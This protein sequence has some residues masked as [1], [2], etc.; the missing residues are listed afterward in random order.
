VFMRSETVLQSSTCQRTPHE[1]WSIERD[2]KSTHWYEASTVFA[3]KVLGDGAGRSCLVVGSP[4]FEAFAL[5]DRGWKVTYLDIRKPPVKFERFVQCDAC[6]MPFDDA[7]FDAVSSACVLTHVGLG[8]YGD[9]I[10]ENGDEKALAEMVRVMKPGAKAAITFGAV[11]DA[12]RMVRDGTAHRI[13]TVAEA[14]RMIQSAGLIL[15]EFAIWEAARKRWRN[16]GERPS[17][18]VIELDYL[19]TFV[20]KPC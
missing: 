4:L 10:V 5:I 11:A 19:S 13:Y 7:S 2:H 12:D 15:M 17:Q 14:R 3:E 8:R 6:D 9:P 1:L 20:G 18:S 16:D